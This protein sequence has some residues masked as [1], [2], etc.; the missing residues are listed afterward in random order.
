MEMSVNVLRIYCDSNRCQEVFD[1]AGFARRFQ[2]LWR[3][4]SMPIERNLVLVLRGFDAGHQ[5]L[6]ALV[7]LNGCRR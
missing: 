1:N 4:R 7:G 3:M 6:P 2:K 5:S